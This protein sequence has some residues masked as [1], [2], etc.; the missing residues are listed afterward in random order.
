MLK[1]FKDAG[2]ITH[3][4]LTGTPDKDW[5]D[6]LKDMGNKEFAKYFLS[7]IKKV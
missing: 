4:A 3:Y 7:R 6:H 2:A 5:N 1:K